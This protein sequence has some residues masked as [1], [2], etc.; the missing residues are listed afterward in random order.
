MAV[1][2]IVSRS[3]MVQRMLYVVHNVL[4]NLSDG[5][6]SSPLDFSLSSSRASSVFVPILDST[7]ASSASSS[8]S[9]FSNINHGS[10]GSSKA[11]LSF[12]S[13]SSRPLAFLTMPSNLSISSSVNKALSRAFIC[14]LG[15]AP[16]IDDLFQD[17]F[18]IFVHHLF[19]DAGVILKQSFSKF[20]SESFSYLHRLRDTG[21]LNHNVV[22]ILR[23]CKRRKSFQ[24]VSPESAADATILKLDQLLFRIMN[25][26]VSNE[27]RINIQRRH[28]IDNDSNFVAMGCSKDVLQKGGLP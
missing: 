1:A 18:S 6:S 12:F 11:L 24:K 2:M 22:D 17:L 10:N 19:R 21:T 3:M 25:L 28:I 13:M 9:S 7:T 8:S 4:N 15:Q 14:E 5:A 20:G 27:R 23:F 16:N 26:M